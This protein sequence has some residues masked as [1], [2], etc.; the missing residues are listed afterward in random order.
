MPETRGGA[1]TRLTLSSLAVSRTPYIRLLAIRAV[2]QPLVGVAIGRLPIAAA[3]LA[4]ILLVRGETGS[5]AIAGIV[6][7]C[8]AI[9]AGI[10]LPIEG[11]LVDRFGQTTVLASCGIVNPLALAG[12]VWAAHEGAPPVALAAIG[13]A[14]GAS[15]PPLSPCMRT[16][17]ASMVG[18]EKLR[19]SAFAL[20]A[21][22]VETAFIVGPL[23]TAAI[24]TAA[25]PSAAVLA[26]AV[27]A[28]TGTAIFVTSRASR[29]WRGEAE[30]SGM[31]G[32]IASR[33]VLALL[34][35][36]VV[37]GASIGSMEIATTA[38]ATQHGSPGLAGAL[39]AVQAA[40]S[41]A[42]GLWYGS[43]HREER[44]ASRYP[45]TTLAIAV[46]FAPLPLAGS[47]GA[48]F[49][50]MALSGFGF[51]PSAAAVFSLI[52]DITPAGTATEASSWLTTSLIVGVAAGTAVAGAVV[53][54]GHARVGFALAATAAIASCLG[55]FAA[56]STWLAA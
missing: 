20:D 21:V 7:A 43:R 52:D 49:P 24:V 29:A 31:L 17:W 47:I 12:L 50:L 28:A 30:A 26:N 3:S 37:S 16:L 54:G 46:C 33:A 15:V 22:M 18:D 32:A 10:S 53:G 6:D 8:V 19:Q 9:A 14:I 2:R 44:A 23:A 41:L 48:L 11:R 39:I 56:R 4:V 36:E 1:L 25:S 13:A 35:V 45:R 5:F 51:A 27:F 55:A 34:A 38:F 42:G 40:A